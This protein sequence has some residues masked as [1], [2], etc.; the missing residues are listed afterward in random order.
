MNTREIG[1]R[2]I[3][4]NVE[5]ASCSFVHLHELQGQTSIWPK[6]LVDF[7]HGGESALADMPAESPPSNHVAGAGGWCRFVFHVS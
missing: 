5:L 4:K 3:E 2:D 1:M 7:P 6:R